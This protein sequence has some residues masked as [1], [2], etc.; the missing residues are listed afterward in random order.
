M[1][2]RRMHVTRKIK[3]HIE[4]NTRSM[5]IIF[6]L[7]YTQILLLKNTHR[8]ADTY[9]VYFALCVF[10]FFMLRACV[11]LFHVF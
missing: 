7:N 6:K 1:Q 11:F 3:I 10:S 2:Q 5:Y 8:D 4:R 9:C